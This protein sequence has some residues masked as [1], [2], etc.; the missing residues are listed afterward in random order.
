MSSA[1]SFRTIFALVPVLVITF[2]VVKSLGVVEDKK[3][4]LNEFMRESGLSQITYVEG[5]QSQPSSPGAQEST[6]EQ[7]SL[8]DKIESV[9]DRAESQLTVGRLGPIGAAL[10]IWAAI[11]LLSTVES[12]LNR[13]FE[14]PSSRSFGRRILLY[15]SAVT[16][17]PLA[18]IGARHLGDLAASF[19]RDL[20]V[21]GTIA[22]WLNWAWPV[23]VGVVLLGLL[24]RLLPNTHVRRRAA[25]GGAAATVVLWLIAKWG[26]A[27]Y[28]RHVGKQSIYGA[29]GLIPLFLMWL[30]LSWLIF[31]FG[32]ELAHT[33][34][35]LSRLQLTEAIK[36]RILSQWD[37]LAALLTVARANVAGEQPIRI[38]QVSATLNLSDDPTA[39]LLSRLCEEGLIARTADDEGETYLLTKSAHTMR[40]SDVLRI[41]SIYGDDIATARCAAE[42]AKSMKEIQSQ[43]HANIEEL[44]IEQLVERM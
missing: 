22:L 35:N 38:E 7:I 5:S 24:Y 1:L 31:L 39:S 29:M 33:A 4:L 41:G 30:N 2:L 34:A 11:T 25:F 27:L 10:L 42:I 37:L 14:A 12:S 8:A 15:W 43:V 28:L 20:P 40:V 21:L 36:S 6:G 19:M 13:I 16:L 44:T 3:R 17:G 18:L 26:F 9:M 32:A 23:I